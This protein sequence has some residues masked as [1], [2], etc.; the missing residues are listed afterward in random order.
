[1]P[2]SLRAALCSL[3]LLFAMLAWTGTSV[4]ATVLLVT[5]EQS[6][7][8]LEEATAA[9]R[10]ALARSVPAGEIATLSWREF[11]EERASNSRVIVTVGTQA[12]QTVAGRALRQPVLYTLLPR[13]SFQSLPSR[14]GAR[15]SAIFLDQPVARQMALLAEALPQWQRL[16]LISSAS[17]QPLA[18]EIAA[19]AR[20]MQPILETIETERDL[21]P[22]LQRA[23]AQP[24]VLLALPDSAVFNSYT[25]QNVLLTAYRHRSPV[26][27]FSPSYVRAGA[28]L[29]LYSTP[30]QIG[31]QAAEAVRAVLDGGLL[32][33][34][35][36]PRRFEIGINQNVARSLGITL[37]PAEQIASRVARREL[38]P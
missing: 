20:P 36:P 11:S 32:P 26:V 1:M 30:T 17:S 3:L 10:N 23:L 18:Q 25:I 9:I 16:A 22:A 19:A 15:V 5:G 35:Q 31:E 28:L 33:A 13:E 34:P 24:A 7:S 29:A 8:A 14:P 38:R 4:A 37:D 2:Q 6:G 21:F 27:G 12:A